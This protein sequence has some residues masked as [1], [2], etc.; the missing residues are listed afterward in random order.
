MILVLLSE[1]VGGMNILTFDIEEWYLEKILHGGRTFKYQSY[2]EAFCRLMDEL[3]RL[4]IK[5][6]FFCVGQLAKEFP[7]V[8][9]TIAMRGHEVGCHSNEHTWLNKMSEKALRK[10]TTE[11]IKILEDVSEQRVVSYRAPAFSIGNENKWMFE[12]LAENG[13]ENDSSVYPAKRDFGG[14]TDFENKVPT[15]IQYKGIML[16]E[17]PIPI[18]DIFGA[19]FAYSGGGYF[20]LFPLSFV[21]MEMKKNEYSMI[22]L[23]IADLIKETSRIMTRKEYE[24]YFKEPGTLFARYKRYFKANFGKKKAWEKMESL[25]SYMPFVS[26]A[27]ANESIDWNNVRKYEL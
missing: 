27:V 4:G 21:K 9:K 14:F 15:I 1:K 6:T 20:R 23:H 25:I 12:V 11:A 10:D 2:D 8:V 26:I 19:S 5:A 16:K 3:D 24:D 13:I 7:E 22:Y 18:C 17:F